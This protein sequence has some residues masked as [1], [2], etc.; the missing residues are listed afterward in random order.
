MA[1]QTLRIGKVNLGRVSKIAI[2]L[3]D[4]GDLIDKSLLKGADIAE[5]RIDQF[6]DVTPGHIVD[7]I[8]KVKRLSLPVIGTI[9]NKKEGG[10]RDISSSKRLELFK[11]IFPLVDAVDIELSSRKIL[12]KVISLAKSDRKTV[13]V[14]YHNFTRTPPSIFLTRKIISAKKEGSDIVKISVRVNSQKDFLRLLRLT[15]DK[16]EDNLIVIAMG[17][18]GIASRIFFPL[19]GSLLTYAYVDKPS[20]PGQVSLPE[21]NR[22]FESLK[23]AE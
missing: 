14:S 2:V 22:I 12:G 3:S 15:I 10:R 6:K 8:G 13:I 7:V 17:R 5:I 19:I 23:R 11:K 18:K 20:A 9:R 4:N 21:M 1:K 16:K